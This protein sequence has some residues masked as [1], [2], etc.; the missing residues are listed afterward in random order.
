MAK[1][2]GH[3]ELGASKQTSEFRPAGELFVVPERHLTFE[4]PLSMINIA[5]QVRPDEDFGNMNELVSSIR[6]LGVEQPIRVARW[7]LETARQ[8]VELNNL[9]YPERE[10]RNPDE[11]V[12]LPDG[13][14]LVVMYGHRRFIGSAVANLETIPAKISEKPTF[15]EAVQIQTAENLHNRPSPVAFARGL[16]QVYRLGQ[17]AGMY[18]NKAV[19]ARASGLS[20]DQA[21]DALRFCELPIEIQQLVI[22]KHLSYATAIELSR[23]IPAV[24]QYELNQLRFSVQQSMEADVGAGLVTRSEVEDRLK[25]VKIDSDFLDVRVR[26]LLFE[27]LLFIQSSHMSAKKAAKYIGQ[28]AA[29]LRG[30]QELLLLCDEVRIEREVASHRN[31]ARLHGLEALAS[32]RAIATTAALFAE[33]P[34][35]L[36]AIVSEAPLQRIL[37]AAA[38]VM[39]KTGD[40]LHTAGA[41]Q[42]AYNASAALAALVE[43]D[44]IEEEPAL[45]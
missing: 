26:A 29:L 37:G 14:C 25:A 32:T 43:V 31:R 23:L 30:Q 34:D 18:P 1:A 12:V 9:A 38:V 19:F 16:N 7:D 8:Y 33:R 36:A 17:A 45:F 22:E 13:S 3:S 42:Q 10:P 35:E 27:H 2:P 41:R 11:L 28:Q 39:E 44:A 5:H 21:R 4:V 24:Q 40:V 15:R 6:T 20:V